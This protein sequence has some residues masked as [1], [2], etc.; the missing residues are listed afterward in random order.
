MTCSSPYP[1]NFCNNSVHNGSTV[2]RGDIAFISEQTLL[3][4]EKSDMTLSNSRT[5]DKGIRHTVRQNQNQLFC[6]KALSNSFFLSFFY[7]LYVAIEKKPLI[8]LWCT[9][10]ISSMVWDGIAGEQE[11]DN[12]QG[13]SKPAWILWYLST[14]GIYSVFI[15][16]IFSPLQT[17]E[18][19]LSSHL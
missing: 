2:Y 5:S 9:V 6:T 3:V 19:E 8:V 18:K 14:L 7:L 16:R 11:Q 12:K 10:S 15:C 4:S 1:S 13:N 17:M